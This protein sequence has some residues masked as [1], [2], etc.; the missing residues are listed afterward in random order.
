MQPFNSYCDDDKLHTFV[1]IVSPPFVPADQLQKTMTPLPGFCG[2]FL[3]L[4]HWKDFAI[5]KE[6]ALKMAD[7]LIIALTSELIEM[8]LVSVLFKPI[9]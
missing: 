5:K 6:T 2:L 1:D 7:F 3:L 4:L 8:Q 9:N